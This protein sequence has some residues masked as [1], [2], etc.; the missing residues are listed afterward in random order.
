M[1][2]NESQSEDILKQF[3]REIWEHKFVGATGVA[4]LVHSTWSLGTLFGGEQPDGGWALVGWLATAFLIAFSLDIGQISTSMEIKKHGLTRA[5]GWTFFVFAAATYYLQWLYMAHH[6]PLLDSAL[7]I[8][9]EWLPLV[10]L[11]R[12]GAIWIVPAFLPMSTVLYTFSSTVKSVHAE[13]AESETPA[14]LPIVEVPALAK[15]A[16]KESYLLPIEHADEPDDLPPWLRETVARCEC[17]WE[18]TYKDAK[19]AR[20]GL[21]G[22]KRHCEL[23]QKPL[24]ANGHTKE[25]SHET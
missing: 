10:T 5:R 25:A 17:G 20:M 16:L 4:A 1:R 3:L 7:G 12:D 19:A 2:V 6:M 13:K 11:M 8:R 18:S 15:P 23:L 9:A 22:H 14:P 24:S 21:N